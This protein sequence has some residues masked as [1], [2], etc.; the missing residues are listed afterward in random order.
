M[1]NF[2]FLPTSLV[3]LGRS[4]VRHASGLSFFVGLLK[5]PRAKRA[6]E[7]APTYTFMAVLFSFASI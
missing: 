5:V 6:L 7:P 4:E 1:E 3:Y 2:D